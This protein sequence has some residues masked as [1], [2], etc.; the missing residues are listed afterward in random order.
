GMLRL[1]EAMLSEMGRVADEAEPERALA[2][3]RATGRAY[4]DFALA[5]PGLF[6]VAFAS[7]SRTEEP[8]AVAPP[9]ATGPDSPHP[10]SLLGQALDELELSGAMAPGRRQGAEVLCWS[11]VH[12]Y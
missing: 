5:E 8:G 1:G 10:Y 7:F 6:E 3:L 9:E 11:A 2:R 4:V 12:G